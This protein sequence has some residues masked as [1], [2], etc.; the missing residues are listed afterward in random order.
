VLVA[1]FGLDDDLA[2][3][4][5]GHAVHFLDV[6]GIPVADARGLETMLRGI[7]AKARNDNEALQK[8]NEVFDSFY[9]AYSQKCLGQQPS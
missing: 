6:G 3:A 5:I 2:L 8:A 9:S 1:S 7:K 4:S